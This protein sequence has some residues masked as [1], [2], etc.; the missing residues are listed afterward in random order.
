MALKIQACAMHARWGK[1]LMCVIT[2]DSGV[3]AQVELEATCAYNLNGTV[4]GSFA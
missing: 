1:L 3:R 4:T 2:T